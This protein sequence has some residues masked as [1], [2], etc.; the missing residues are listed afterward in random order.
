MNDPILKMAEFHVH[1]NRSIWSTCRRL[2][3][4]FTESKMCCRRVP[5]ATYSYWKQDFAEHNTAYLAIEALL[6]DN[7][8]ALRVGV[9][10]MGLGIVEGDQRESDLARAM[11]VSGTVR[12][13]MN[14]SPW[15]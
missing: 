5:Y 7:P 6:V 9:L 2:R 3:L 13:R 4:A 8:V 10:L 15:S 12:Y 1:C 14:G 11:S